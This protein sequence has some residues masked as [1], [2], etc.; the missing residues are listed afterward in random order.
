[1]PCGGGDPLFEPFRLADEH[2]LG[3]GI[4]PARQPHITQHHLRVFGEIAVDAD[5]TV[6]RFDLGEA[7]LAFIARGFVRRALAQKDDIGRHFCPGI[8]GK[9]AFCPAGQTDGAEEIGALGDLAADRIAFLV[10]RV[11]RSDEGEQPA[12]PELVEALE[13]EIVVDGSGTV[14]AIARSVIAKGDEDALKSETASEPIAAKEISNGRGAQSPADGELR[15]STQTVSLDAL[16]ESGMTGLAVNCHFFVVTAPPVDQP[17]DGIKEGAFYL[18]DRRIYRKLAG[19]GEPQEL[20]T[21]EAAKLTALIELRD[22][23]NELLAGQVSGD[24]TDRDALRGRLNVRYD[25]FLTRHGPINRT[26]VSVSARR[27]VDGSPVV[28]RKFPNFAAFR[29]D[30]DA[31]KVAAIE[32]YDEATD[33]TAKAAIFFRDII[34]P[35]TEPPVASASDCRPS[36]TARISSSPASPRMSPQQAE[37]SSPSLCERISATPSGALSPA[38]T[39]SS[40]MPSAPARPSP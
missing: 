20:S 38:A 1:M 10:E 14:A 35:A 25:A 9:G 13:K 31:F 6:R 15:R 11:A 37:R 30:P 18:H 32:N 21:G 34:Q 40:I 36:M 16:A 2:R 3:S 7:E 39:P 17:A 23:V 5:R 27:R 22:L 28:I 12:R 33:R 8:L 29:P 4:E 26:V 24:T 19:I